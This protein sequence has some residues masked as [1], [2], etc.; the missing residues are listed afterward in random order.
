MKPLEIRQSAVALELDRQDLAALGR[1][2]RE[3]AGSSWLDLAGLGAA[4]PAEQPL[5]GA[6]GAAC[7]GAGMAAWAPHSM[8]DW[9]K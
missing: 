6:F 5:V 4:Q 2:C 1:V 9:A 7:E 8:H 3:L